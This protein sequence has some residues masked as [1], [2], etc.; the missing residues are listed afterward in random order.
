[1][2][3]RALL[4]FRNPDST[5][6]IN[7]RLRGLFNKGF[8]VGG[9]ITPVPGVLRVDLSPFS[10]VGS[11]GM[12]VREDSQSVRLDVTAGF[13]NYIVIRQ[14]Y[15]PNNAPIVS[16]ESLTEPEFLA[17]GDI[18]SQGPDNPRLI[19]FGVVDVP[20]LSIAVTTQMIETTESDIVDTIGRLHFRGVLSSSLDL[21]GIGTNKNRP[22]DFYI[23]TDGLGTTPPSLFA[24]NGDEWV[25][26]TSSS[27]S[28]D[29]D[30]HRQNLNPDEIHLTDLQAE[31]AAGSVGTP[32][33]LNRYVTENDTRLLS[34]DEAD[35]TIGN[36]IDPPTVS[37]EDA[38]PSDTNRFVTSSKV[39]A[40]PAESSFVFGADSLFIELNPARGPF[41]V[42]MPSDPEAVLG[43]VQQWFNLY[44]AGAASNE[45]YLNS[46]LQQVSILRVEIGDIGSV[47]SGTEVNP[48]GAGV[49]DDLGFYVN[50]TKSLY[51]ILDKPVNSAVRVAYGKRTYLGNLLPHLLTGRGP[52]GGQVDRR[53]MKLLLCT[54]N[55]QFE[56]STIFDAGVTPGKIVS[57]NT[58]TQKFVLADPDGGFPP[59]GVRG[60]ANNVII[61][62]LYT[63]QF[64][65]FSV[66]FLYAD[67]ASPGNLTT[68]PNEWF[69]G[70]AISTTQLLVNS[71]LVP[72][73]PDDFIP[74]IAFPSGFFDPAVQPGSPIYWNGSNNRFEAADSSISAKFP[75]GI[76]GN[77]NNVIQNNKFIS[78][79]GTPYAT[80]VKYYAGAGA[81]AGFLV[82]SP[83]DAYIGVG[84]NSTTLLV[85]TS[86]I[87]VPAKW[88]EEHHA[89]S[90][91]HKFKFGNAAAQSA[92]LAPGSGML[93]LRND[94]NP[95]RID[96]W[97]G[98]TW[99]PGTSSQ[100]VR[101]V[102]LADRT[103]YVRTDGN[104]SNTG[105]VDSAGGAFLTMQAAINNLGKIEQNGFDTVVQVGNGTYTGGVTITKRIF[106]GK[107]TMRGNIGS[108]TSC[109]ISTTNA[110]CIS[111]S[112]D[113]LFVEGFTLQ[114]TVGGGGVTVA[115]NGLVTLGAGMRFG[116][117]AGVHMF[118]LFAGKI[119][120]NA[121]YTIAGGAIAHY[122]AGFSGFLATN[123]L[124]LTVNVTGTPN[125]STAFAQVNSANIFSPS[126]TFIGGAGVTGQKHFG[127]ANGVFY[128][129]GGNPLTYYPGS[130]AGVV[131][132]GAQFA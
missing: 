63:S 121:N 64:N 5:R 92:I 39:F 55:A 114:T 80:G 53:L 88:T 30:N 38:P 11:D 131:N 14:E 50:P 127:V 89:D 107:V 8:F 85:N 51:L 132:T 16:V 13:K 87:A 124:G 1:M 33:D 113:S 119:S 25:D 20:A 29:L 22:G 116:S 3:R 36:F 47:P 54:P 102:L 46:T 128:T 61:E 112:E 109:V 56:D 118:A 32:S 110:D 84:L 73:D 26:I 41:F 100:L 42:G 126:I 44:A 69:I 130:I 35:A 106:S 95:P 74:P 123:A 101:E 105:L 71:S 23:V 7:D 43:T 120:V 4:R 48:Q 59:I 21:P 122:S 96:Y 9:T 58:V 52:K 81:F 31:A 57:F 17:D 28:D 115:G 37:L 104:D 77:N 93:F 68:V 125:F 103:Y 90:G 6:D 97:T 86:A 75:T 129:N 67:K 24:W 10:T 45:E 62:G 83:N 34:Q 18:G 111:V 94:T 99:T 40:A 19:V 66:D 27:V 108:P 78:L 91:Y 98:S 65:L 72:R 76:R 12:F 70:R 15:V 60:N 2:A 79:V 82:T 49:T 117:C